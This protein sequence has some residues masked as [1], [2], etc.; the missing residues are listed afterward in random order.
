MDEI[1]SC[2]RS[3]VLEKLEK[4]NISLSE[5]DIENL[6]LKTILDALILA[7]NLIDAVTPEQWNNL[8]PKLG[9]SFINS[10]KICAQQ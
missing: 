4:A 6:F 9:L 1:Y 7:P 2:F 5:N 10:T 3:N 8:I